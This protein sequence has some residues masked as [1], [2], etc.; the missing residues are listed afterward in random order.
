MQNI[1]SGTQEII[2]LDISKFGMKRSQAGPVRYVFN[3]SKNLMT[4]YL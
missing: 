4:N 3:N 2:F 1:Y